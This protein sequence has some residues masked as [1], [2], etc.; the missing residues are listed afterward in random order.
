MIK[1]GLQ[2]GRKLFQMGAGKLAAGGPFK[3]RAARQLRL[4]GQHVAFVPRKIKTRNDGKRVL[5]VLITKRWDGK[6]APSAC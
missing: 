2:V 6:S 4:D 3:L 1:L 5:N